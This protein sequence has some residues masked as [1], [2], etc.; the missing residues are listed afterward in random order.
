[1]LQE[2]TSR[3][4]NFLKRNK[5]VI[6]ATIG[7]LGV[8]A[9]AV[10]SAKAAVKATKL[11]EEEQKQDKKLTK[12]EIFKKTATTF[13]PPVIVGVATIFC[14]GVS[15]VISKKSQASLAGAYA[16][17]HQ[18]YSKYKD[19]V[20]EI[21]GIEADSQIHKSIMEDKLVE[22]KPTNVWVIYPENNLEL[23]DEDNNPKYLFYD[24]YSDRYF[25]ATMLQ[26][27]NAEY[28]LNRCL[29]QGFF[30]TLNQFYDF[31][32]LDE[33]PFAESIGWTICDGYTWLD[34]E[35]EKIML[36]DNTLECWV[37]RPMFDPDAEALTEY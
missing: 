35:H 27:Q 10:L 18:G 4:V 23:D 1:M 36:D 8:I 6:L 2:L 9:T 25:R 29:T 5:A 37:I 16:L 7:G 17:L 26:V 22:K 11:I 28:H 14:V 20:K 3:A 33:M 21:F 19:K 24:E 15:S 34:F 13:I 30:V 32:G 31:L 12:T